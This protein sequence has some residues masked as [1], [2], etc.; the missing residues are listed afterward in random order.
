MSWETVY[1]SDRGKRATRDSTGRGDEPGRP[2]RASGERPGSSRAAGSGADM[3]GLR[4][5]QGARTC[6]FSKYLY[7]LVG[8]KKS[9]P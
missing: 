2:G 4:I 7:F 3:D 9:R 8:Y 6:F 5:M 1:L